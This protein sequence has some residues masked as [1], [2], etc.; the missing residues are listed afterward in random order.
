MRVEFDIFQKRLVDITPACSASPTQ[1]LNLLTFI[2]LLFS[3][4]NLLIV[5]KIQPAFLC[6]LAS[7]HH[8]I[9]PHR[10]LQPSNFYNFIFLCLALYIV[11]IRAVESES[12]KV[13]KS[14]KVGKSRKSRIWFF[15]RLLAKKSTSLMLSHNNW[16]QTNYNFKM[17]ITPERKVPQRS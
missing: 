16:F 1:S 4:K 10:I 6:C 15:I 12:L 8:I 3:K 2:L 7:Q 11:C 17:L 13:R 5:K 14:L 9:G